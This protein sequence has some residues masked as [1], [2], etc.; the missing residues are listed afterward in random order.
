VEKKFESRILEMHEIKENT[1]ISQVMEVI[2][3]LQTVR[4]VKIQKTVF[5]LS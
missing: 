2:C 4:K 1:S 3:S 5:S